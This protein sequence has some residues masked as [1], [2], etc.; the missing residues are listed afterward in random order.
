MKSIEA[1]AES[2]DFGPAQDGEDYVTL[3]FRVHKD[4]DAIPG[5]WD[6]TPRSPGTFPW[7]TTKYPDKAE[8]RDDTYAA[9]TSQRT[10]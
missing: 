6:L 7:A 9:R 8:E 1:V 2:A 4:R 3:T 10:I 5:I